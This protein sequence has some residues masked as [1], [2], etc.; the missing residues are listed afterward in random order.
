MIRSK[1][2]WAEEG[3][4]PTRYFCCL[5]SRNY[6]NKIISK[7]EKEDG[8][9]KRN[10]QEILSEVKKFY[11][12][13]Y[14]CHDRE[15]NTTN[16]MEILRNLQNHTILEEIEK[17]EFGRRNNRRGNINYIEKKEK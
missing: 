5:A 13:L 16:N 11:S 12:D 4:K 17:N 14:N 7:I 8:S 2:K 1:V 9:I 3:E 10:Q 6:V 15:H